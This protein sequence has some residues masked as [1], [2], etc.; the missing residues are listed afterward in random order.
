MDCWLVQGVP[1]LSPKSSWKRFRLKGYSG[2]QWMDGLWNW[3]TGKVS[4]LNSSFKR[5][6]LLFEYKSTHWPQILISKHKQ[7]PLYFQLSHHNITKI[8]EHRWAS[9]SLNNL[10]LWWSSVS[11]YYFRANLQCCLSESVSFKNVP[12]CDSVNAS[13]APQQQKLS[14]TWSYFS[15]GSIPSECGQKNL[16]TA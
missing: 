8:L 4:N 12:V 10:Q 13:S 5:T 6:K 15:G 3:A 7:K 1:I 9:A 16:I 2:G 11:E 14:E